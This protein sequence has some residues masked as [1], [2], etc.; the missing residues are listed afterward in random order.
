[1]VG[2]NDGRAETGVVGLEIPEPPE[3]DA[4]AELVKPTKK[5]SVAT[6]KI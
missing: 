5:K 1:M 6:Q 4:E 3:R 2:D